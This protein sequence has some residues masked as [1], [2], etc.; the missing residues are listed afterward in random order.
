MFVTPELLEANARNKEMIHQQLLRKEVFNIMEKDKEAPKNLNKELIYK[1]ISSAS[2]KIGVSPIII[3]RI[4]E[5]E[6][7]FTMPK[8]YDKGSGMMQLTIITV[9]DMYQRRQ[10]YDADIYPILDKYGS[11]ENLMKEI[12]KNP[13]LN[14]LI[15][16]A[17]FKQ[18]LKQANGDVR[19]ALELYNAHPSH[20][21]EYSNSVYNK[22]LSSQSRVGFCIEG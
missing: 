19:K 3:A 21:I 11:A 10:L 5:R 1:Y 14:I 20:K 18:K 8:S 22:I 16:T 7:N 15:G 13:E 4:I 9:E 17:C 2:N 12:R 6:S